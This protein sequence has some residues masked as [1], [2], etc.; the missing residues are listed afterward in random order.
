MSGTVGTF[1]LDEQP[2]LAG[3]VELRVVLSADFRRLDG[4]LTPGCVSEGEWRG[5]IR[6]L[7]EDLKAVEK[8]GLRKLKAAAAAGPQPITED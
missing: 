2:W 5:C 3:G 4:A 7:I 8:R 6:D 1:A